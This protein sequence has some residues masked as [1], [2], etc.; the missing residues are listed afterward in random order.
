MKN[1]AHNVPFATIDKLA[2]GYDA[3]RIDGALIGHF[4]TGDQAAVAAWDDYLEQNHKQHQ[5]AARREHER[6]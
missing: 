6:R 4:E 5:R 1:G 2:S 3:R